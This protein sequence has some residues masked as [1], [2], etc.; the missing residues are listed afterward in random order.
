[1]AATI[2][3]AE[4]YTAMLIQTALDG[5]ASNNGP[6]PQAFQMEAVYNDTQLCL[7]QDDTV[8]EDWLLIRAENTWDIPTTIP[9]NFY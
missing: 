8:R 3:S 5:L 9:S 6:S 1:M 2:T 4:L 7:A